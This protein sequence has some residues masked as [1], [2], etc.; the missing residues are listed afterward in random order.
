MD[1]EM[2]KGSRI[3]LVM[4]TTE[5]FQRMGGLRVLSKV[6]TFHLQAL[7]AGKSCL[8]FRGTS[9]LKLLYGTI[10]VLPQKCLLYLQHWIDRNIIYLADLINDNA[11]ILR[12]EEFLRS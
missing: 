10:S 1:K 12:N 3:Y 6:S 8:D 9:P 4:Y 7:T 2:S 11:Q 5:Y